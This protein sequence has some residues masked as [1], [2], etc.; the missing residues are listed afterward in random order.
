MWGEFASQS[1]SDLKRKTNF[2]RNGCPARTRTSINGIRIRCLTI[3]RRGNGGG[4][5]GGVLRQVKLTRRHVPGSA[6]RARP[7]TLRYM[8]STRHAARRR[9]NI[10]DWY[11]WRN[12][13]RRRR[14]ARRG[15]ASGGDAS[16]RPVA[17][18]HRRATPLASAQKQARMEAQKQAQPAVGQPA[19][20]QPAVGQPA[21]GQNHP[22]PP[23]P[24]RQQKQPAPLQHR[25]PTIPRANPGKSRCRFTVRPMPRSI[26]APTTAAC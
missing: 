14:S 10:S 9:E 18:L 23:R 24:C 22:P 25:C 15:R 11:S 7:E 4:H 17:S 8:S 16:P 5:L 6:C 12:S 2:C 20:G 3:R 19:V 1:H 21:S 13:I 26:S